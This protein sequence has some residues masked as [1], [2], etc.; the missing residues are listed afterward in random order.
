MTKLMTIGGM[1]MIASSHAAALCSTTQLAPA[2]QAVA[3]DELAALKRGH[4]PARSF[5]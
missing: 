1:P 3:R 2:K 5:C 4:K